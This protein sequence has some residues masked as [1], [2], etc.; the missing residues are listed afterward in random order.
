VK[1]RDKFLLGVVAVIAVFAGAWMLVIQPKRQ[2]AR[3][4]ETQITAAR[5]DLAGVSARA[6]QYRAARERL[7]HHPQAFAKAGRALPNR[8]SM[9]ELLR[10]LTRTARGTGV[11]IGDL[12]VSGGSSD[13][14][15]GSTSSTTPGISSVGLQ[16]SFNGDFLALHRYLE[17]LQRFVQV[18]SKD[19]AARGRL[20]SLDNVQLSQG[21]GGLS[22]KVGATVYVLQPGSLTPGASTT[23]AP[24]ATA[25]PATP[26]A[27][28][29]S[30][31]PAA[32]TP[33]TGGA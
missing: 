12:T 29:A 32:A 5:T 30:P 24:A 19:V 15:A 4:L 10:T 23:A 25:A 18:S 16:L 22:A 6:A 9:P 17:R 28:P 31:A 21:D 33:T 3:K 20:V 11:T 7:L 13:S 1:S 2:D 8:V 14:G 27:A 26:G